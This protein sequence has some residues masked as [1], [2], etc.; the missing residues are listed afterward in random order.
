MPT[1]P[2]PTRLNRPARNQAGLV[3]RISALRGVADPFDRSFKTD[4]ENTEGARA[5]LRIGTS[6]KLAQDFRNIGGGTTGRRDNFSGNLEQLVRKA[7]ARG[8]I[9]N[10]GDKAIANQQL[11]DRVT[12]AR[13]GIQRQGQVADIFG[14]TQ[15]I[16]L[17]IDTANR[18]ARNLEAQA[19]G[20]ALGSIAGGLSAVIKDKFSF[21][22]PPFVP[23]DESVNQG[24]G[25]ADFFNF[26]TSND[27]FDFDPET[28][29][30]PAG[31]SVFG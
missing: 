12:L 16:Q 13:R 25:A 11:K 19:I 22:Q 26:P 29:G 30:Q 17:G 24:T 8:Q 5:R 27:S 23:V 9:E 28:I 14:N 7:K 2:I 31:G 3:D 6:S 18:Q 4:V 20:G 15:R 1:D 21:E 10:R